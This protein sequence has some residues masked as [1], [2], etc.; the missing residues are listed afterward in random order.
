M[1][2]NEQEYI[3]HLNR[4]CFQVDTKINNRILLL[5]IQMVAHIDLDDCCLVFY[6]IPPQFVAL[7]QY[8]I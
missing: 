3:R 5:C 6:G 8:T 1:R 2:G 7:P 4:Q